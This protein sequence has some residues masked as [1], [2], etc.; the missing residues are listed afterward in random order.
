VYGEGDEEEKAE[1][2]KE[3]GEVNVSL[4]GFQN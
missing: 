1:C 3:R 4:A 2:K